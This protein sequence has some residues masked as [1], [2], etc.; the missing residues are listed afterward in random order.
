MSSTLVF[1]YVV[2]VHVALFLQ[3][4]F[5]LKMLAFLKDNVLAPRYQ[6]K[7]AIEMY[8]QLINNCLDAKLRSLK[9]YGISVWF[10]VFFNLFHACLQSA[11]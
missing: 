5:S 3:T 9:L 2:F 7:V 4:L 6:P 10:Y 11:V 8:Q 1:I